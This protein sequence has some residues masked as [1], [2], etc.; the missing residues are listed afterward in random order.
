MMDPLAVVMRMTPNRL[1]EIVS[2]WCRRPS[3]IS[4][5]LILMLLPASCPADV[6]ASDV[7]EGTATVRP[8]GPMFDSLI[9]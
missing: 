6:N 4:L 3:R 2:K 9:E 5:T 1:D 8:I 7:V